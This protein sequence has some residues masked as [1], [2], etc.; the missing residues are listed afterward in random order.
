MGEGAAA[1]T[2]LLRGQ[3]IEISSTYQM[4][5]LRTEQRSSPSFS[6]ARAGRSRAPQRVVST[7]Q[8]P[9]PRYNP[10]SPTQIHI[11]EHRRDA[12]KE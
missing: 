3:H 6:S 2:D 5:G 9:G 4:R 7:N 11:L 12:R 8:T 10:V 1:A